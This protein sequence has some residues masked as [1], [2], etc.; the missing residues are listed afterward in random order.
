MG[1]MPQVKKLLDMTPERRQTVLFSATLDGDVAELT[2]R[3]QK[4][5]VRHEVG[6][7]GHD[8]GDARHHFWKVEHA[9]RLEQVADIA[10]AFESTLVF[11]RTRRG[12]DRLANQLDKSGVKAEAI[13]GGR[14]QRQRDRALRNFK[15]GQ[16]EALVATDVAARGI[17]VDGVDC[18]VHFDPPEDHKTYLHRSGRTA[19]A[20]A[21]GNVVSLVQ[22]DQV[23]STYNL[24]DSLGLSGAIG[25]PS[26]DSLLDGGGEKLGK[27]SESN[28]DNRSRSQ[29]KNNSGSRN[30]GSRRNGSSSRSSQSSDHNRSRRPRRSGGGDPNQRST[31]AN[32]RDGNRLASASDDRDGNRVTAVAEDRDG[33]TLGDAGGNAG[34]RRK[35]GA[36]GARRNSSSRSRSRSGGGSGSGGSGRSYGGANQ[37]R[38]RKPSGNRSGG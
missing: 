37:Q 11:T 6:G 24:Q 3:Y 27:R 15:N 9:K 21:G 14:S 33:N 20:G 8:S 34:R 25:S 5:P 23:R 10:V 26:V 19:R 17:H 4:D 29:G 18:V 13:H 36:S 12:A 1:F 28:G 35:P 31:G 38:R 2:K 16:I 7:D 22:H 32:D 30:S